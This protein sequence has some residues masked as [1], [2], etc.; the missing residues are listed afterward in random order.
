M[1]PFREGDRSTVR[2]KLRGLS[3]DQRPLPATDNPLEGGYPPGK[4]PLHIGL[5]F[6]GAHFGSSRV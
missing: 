6:A 2:E 1:K 5:V 3:L 4:D